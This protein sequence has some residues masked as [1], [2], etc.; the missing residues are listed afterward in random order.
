MPIRLSV[1]LAISLLVLGAS[2]AFADGMLND[3]ENTRARGGVGNYL[4]W[5]TNRDLVNTESAFEEEPT[6]FGAEGLMIR[7]SSAI[8]PAK[9]INFPK[10]SARIEAHEKSELDEIAS[11]L[12]A[13]PALKAKITGFTDT[14]GPK[15]R[16][17]ILAG[18][19]AEAVV[20][21]LKER[22]VSENQ[23]TW[24]AKG[25]RDP[26][27]ENSTPEGRARNRRVEILYQ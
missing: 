27:D 21:G 20:R 1:T 14:T 15:S 6:F 25:E 23:L 2:Y 17:E 12:K 19:R 16:N 13:D 22:G 10:A 4:F 8:A 7:Q 24:S 11:T 18:A 3:A 9:T 5:S 26:I